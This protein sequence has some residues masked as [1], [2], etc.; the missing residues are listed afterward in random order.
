MYLDETSQHCSF[1]ANYLK[2]RIYKKY[3]Y[4]CQICL[5]SKLIG[6]KVNSATC[7]IA[8]RI[9]RMNTHKKVSEI[10]ELIITH[11]LKFFILFNWFILII[12]VF[13]FDNITVI[14]KGK[15]KYIDRGIFRSSC[16]D[17][18]RITLA[19]DLIFRNIK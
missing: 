19:S 11:F 8:L 7:S 5:K 3:K 13:S 12:S 6:L 4:A 16:H 17:E 10:F 15:Y 18:K 9:I 14:C 2:L 1:K